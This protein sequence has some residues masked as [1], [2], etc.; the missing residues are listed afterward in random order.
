M[1]RP[2]LRLCVSDE[3]TEGL[4]PK[5]VEQVARLLD[6]IA[7]R[8][9]AILRVERKLAIALKMSARLYVMGHG[10]VVFE[11]SQA[12]LA[13]TNAIAQAVW[14]RMSKPSS[15][16]GGTR[17]ARTPRRSRGKGARRWH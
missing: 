10:Q 17:T 5:L 4:A 6:D 8:G 2:R 13:A 14:P 11:G 16:V 1:S 15:A 7:K 9:I 3:P 12:A